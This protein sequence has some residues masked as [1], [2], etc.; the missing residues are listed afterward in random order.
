MMIDIL[1][2]HIPSYFP[3]ESTIV[4]VLSIRNQ[5]TPEDKGMPF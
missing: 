1:L 3:G 5:A 2:Y 4:H